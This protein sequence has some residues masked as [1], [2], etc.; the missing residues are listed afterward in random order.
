M[1]LPPL[2]CLGRLHRELAGWIEPTDAV[3]TLVYSLVWQIAINHLI[4]ALVVG[5]YAS[6]L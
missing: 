1:D 6:K 4:V 5:V 2:P 3:A